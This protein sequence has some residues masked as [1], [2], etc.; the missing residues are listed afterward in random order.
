[1][2][3]NSSICQGERTLRATAGHARRGADGHPKTAYCRPWLRRRLGIPEGYDANIPWGL[4]GDPIVVLPT[5][6]C[7][8]C[9]TFLREIV[10]GEGALLPGGVCEIDHSMQQWR[11][12][13][14]CLCGWKSRPEERSER[15]LVG[16]RR[17]TGP[18]TLVSQ[19]QHLNEGI[20]VGPADYKGFEPLGNNG[21]DHGPTM[22][23]GS[24]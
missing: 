21:G 24:T 22:S 18:C 19:T 15:V 11:V 6:C 2:H 4:Q 10:P 17:Q 3:T 1:M 8:A 16:G 7:H 20:D 9:A 14:T 12:R 5:V 13:Q 23:R